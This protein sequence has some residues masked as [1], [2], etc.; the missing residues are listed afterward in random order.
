MKD[1]L[2]TMILMRDY[3]LLM[4]VIAL[5]SQLRIKTRQIRKIYIQTSL[6]IAA[7]NL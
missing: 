6:V 1:F 7:I 4:K 5:L 2:M 3:T